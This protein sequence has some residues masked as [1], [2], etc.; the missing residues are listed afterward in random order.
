METF[1]NVSPF[2]ISSNLLCNAMNVFY[3]YHIEGVWSCLLDNG[4]NEIPS[5]TVM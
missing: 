3:Y 2:L 1:K 4:K 5:A